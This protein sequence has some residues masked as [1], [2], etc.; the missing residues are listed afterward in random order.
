[1]TTA[2]YNLVSME[3]VQQGKEI[4]TIVTDHSPDSIFKNSK[5]DYIKVTNAI[6]ANLH[7]IIPICSNA[8]ST[9]IPSSRASTA[10]MT[11]TSQKKIIVAG[12]S[13]SGGTAW[14]CLFQLAFRPD[15]FLGLDPFQLDPHATVELEIPTLNIGFS[16]T[17]CLVTVDDAAKASYETSGKNHRVLYLINNTSTSPHNSHS[18][19][20]NDVINSKDNVTKITTNNTPTTGHCSFTD[21]GCFGPICPVRE[22]AAWVRA[23]VGFSIQ[24]FVQSLWTGVYRKEDYILPR[25]YSTIK[26]GAAPV[27]YELYVNQDQVV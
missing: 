21:R 6:V 8:H 11:M 15:G 24:A 18:K 10:R 20:P 23:S 17:T 14:N 4:V 16:E 13:A 12:H 1:M 19:T 25:S 7:S 26:A 5:K 22:G 9:N 2:D 27:L 3:M